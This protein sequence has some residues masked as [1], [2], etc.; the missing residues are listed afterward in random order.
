MTYDNLNNYVKLTGNIGHEIEVMEKDDMEFTFFSLA[1]RDSYRDEQGEF[2]Q[3]EEVW[4]Q[5]AVFSPHV[6]ARV[7]QFKKGTRISVSGKISY[8][9][10]QAVLEDGRTVT[11]NAAVINARHVEQAPLVPKSK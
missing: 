2:H 3:L 8:Q 5:I 4:H 7:K 11:K 6:L 9:P 1:T 10:F